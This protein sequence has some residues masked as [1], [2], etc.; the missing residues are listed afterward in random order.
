MRDSEIARRLGVNQSTVLRRLG[1]AHVQERCR[2][3]QRNRLTLSGTRGI[4]GR[5]AGRAS[6]DGAAEPG[7]GRRADA[8][9][10]V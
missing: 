8:A 10:A 6:R 3:P 2:A 7:T 5:G 4:Q 1:R 9:A